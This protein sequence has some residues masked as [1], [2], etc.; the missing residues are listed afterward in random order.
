M[1]RAAV[2]IRTHYL[3]EPLL[4]LAGRLR[5]DGMFD[6]FILADET[7][8][9]LD[10]GDL[11]KVSLTVA[12]TS[13]LGLYHAA[14]NLLWRCGDYGLYVA[15]QA[16]P[17]YDAFWMVE[18]DVRL[19]AARPS[20][21]LARFPGPDAIDLLAARLGPAAADWDWALT[22]DAAEGPI[23][24]CLFALVRLSVRAIDVLLEA[25]RQASLAHL[26]LG[27]D[28]AL[29]SND[30][31]FV[32]STLARR[33][34]ACRDLNDFGQIYQEVGFSFWLPLT[35]REIEAGGREGWIYHPVLSGQRYFIKLCRLAMRHGVLDELEPVVERL[36]GVEWTPEEAKGHRRAIELLK[37]QQVQAAVA[38]EATKT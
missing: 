18:P 37:A 26:E 35:E 19:N 33:G 27:R 23:I 17:R 13:G 25:R 29:W 6:V 32:A 15:R 14:P 34:L 3:D 7:H 8:G 28:P 22:L 12:A 31:V 9:A 30:E 36:T 24:R 4:D 16:L 2:L 11:P 5:R 1:S 21:I 38:V 10:T 20:D